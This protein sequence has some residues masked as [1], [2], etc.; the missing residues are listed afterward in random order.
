[1]NH[2]HMAPARVGQAEVEQPVLEHLAS[3]GDRFALEHCE[4]RD[5]EHPRLVMLQE[6][7]LPRWAMQGTP[8]LNAALQGALAAVPLLAGEGPLQVQQQGLGFQL[9]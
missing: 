1:M 9:G 3:H 4:I 7:H 5:A 2:L 8:L 6:H